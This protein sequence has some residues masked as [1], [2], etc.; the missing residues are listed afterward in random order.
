MKA[1]SLAVCVLLAQATTPKPAL[2]PSPDPA[3]SQFTADAGLLLV[4]IKATAVADYEG[5]IRRLQE[6]LAK[7]SD[8]Q[9][10]AA[11]K[12]WHVYK[13]REGDA[14]GNAIYV[15]V[16]LPT[17]PNFDYRPSL[18]LDEL[19]KDLA[20]DVLAKYQ[21]AFAAPPTKLNL[22]EFARMSVMPVDPKKP[23]GF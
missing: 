20:P 9:R 8:P 2:P 5:T 1:L 15:H 16:M 21:D 4:V 23:G 7:D 12:G 17:V 14:K 18:L 6:A 13:T 22:V 3:S 10:S 11:A 19:V